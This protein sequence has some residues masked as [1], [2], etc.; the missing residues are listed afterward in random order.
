MSEIRDFVMAAPLFDNHEHQAGYSSL[1][2]RRETLSYRE[3]IGYAGA[4]LVTAMGTEPA[5]GGVEELSDEEFFDLWKAVRTTGYGRATERAC[6]AVADSDYTLENAEAI[7]SALREMA[8]DRSGEQ[9]YA[10]LLERAGVRWALND[11]CWDSPTDLKFFTGEEYPD[12]FGQAIRYDD[13]LVLSGRS[14]LKKLERALDR[15]I[16]TLAALDDA[17]DAYTEK[18]AGKGRLKAMKCGLAYRRHLS[19]EDSSFA[20]AERAFQAVMQGRSTELRPL[21]D[22]LFHRFVQRAEQFDLP[23][24]VHTGYLAG[25]YGDLSRGDPTGL[26]PVFDRYRKVRFDLFHAGWPYSELMG[27]IGKEFPNVWLDLC[28]AWSMN[29][30]RMETVLSEWLAAVPHNKI[31]GFGGDTGS[32]FPLVGYALQA[33][34]GVANVLESKV[35]R[36]DMD[37]ATA[38]SVAAR[39]MHEN[40]REF[41]G[42]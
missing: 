1:E 5:E 2:E 11:P 36:G 16:H 3:F 38:R 19:F 24:Q 40:A 7:T 28:W 21:H 14:S 35:A 9:I 23:V 34:R 8:A 20:G 6:R 13:V 42:I 18:A 17:L 26:M 33:R 41:Y 32:P 29:P 10:D 30:A 4:D 27:A 15:S 31:F 22:Y 37:E 12:G 39:I 25:N